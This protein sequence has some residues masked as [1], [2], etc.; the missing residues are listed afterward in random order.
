MRAMNIR[1][2]TGHNGLKQLKA[3][4]C[5]NWRLYLMEALGL[6]IFMVSA[7]FF[8]GLLEANNS[9]AHLAIPNAFART[10]ITG[11]LMGFTAL[12][13]FYSPATA[14]S[15]SHINPAVTITFLRL[16]KM[17]RWDALFFIIFQLAGGILAVYIMA[18]VMGS[19]LTAQPVHYVCTV[20]GNTGV[21]AAAITEFVIAVITMLAVLFTS[22]HVTLKKYTRVIAACLVCIYVVVAGPVSG[23]GMN[24]SR[25]LA[26]AVNAGTY[27]AL[28]IYMLMPFAGMLAAAEIFL[29]TKERAYKKAKQIPVK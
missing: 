4:F 3:S 24:P 9:V 12:L 25:T 18:L 14:S 10:I 22:A 13:I 1:V 15:G 26:S 17:C 8:G 21:V 11:L 2:V 28:W 20:P 5:K 19:T 7:C 27:T 23:F 29:F 16:G 6:G